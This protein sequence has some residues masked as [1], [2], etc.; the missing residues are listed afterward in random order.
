MRI[1]DPSFSILALAPFS[2]ALSLDEPPV[3]TVDLH[4][5]DDALAE[6][7]PTVDISMDATICP[8]PSLQVEI[9][10]MADFKPKNLVKNT[11]FLR[12]LH[13]ARESISGN[14]SPADLSVKYPRVAE[15]ITFPAPSSQE[16]KAKS[17]AI[18]D[19]LS[20]VD[21]GDEPSSGAA[22]SGDIPDQIDTLTAGILAT[23]LA[24]HDFRLMEQAWRGAQLVLRQAGSGTGTTVTMTLALLTQDAPSLVMD[25]LESDLADTPPDL[26]LLD[27]NLSHSPLDM[28][29]LHRVMG[30][31]ES[32]LAPALIP[33]GT[34]FFGI[35]DWSRFDTLGFIPGLLEGAEYGKW[36]TMAE[37]PGGGWLVP[38]VNGV[39]ARPAHRAEAGF[40]NRGFNETTPLFL[41]PAWGLAAL[42]TRSIAE[43]KRPTR[44]NDRATVT[45]DGMPMT[46][47]ASPTSTELSLDRERLKDF[48]QAGIT[49]LT[50]APGSDQVFVLAN[51]TLDS[52]PLAFRLFLSQLTGFLIG[53]ATHRSEEI[54][55]LEYD[56]PQAIS[57]FMQA[58]GLPAPDDLT[59]TTHEEQDGM[60]PLEISL[61]PPPEILPGG[62]RFTFG[63]GW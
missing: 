54:E 32:M 4:S 12:E 57:L 55:D 56:L 31:A 11:P 5:L 48:K 30:L 33:M 13:E 27:R 17:S 37:S 41:S 34:D 23:I 16:T 39:L 61:T 51:T 6:L 14:G 1:D 8:L 2:P 43:H 50:T 18:D 42:C 22:L 15:M 62:Q 24:D 7:A 53:L 3:F 21:T 19:I 26:I 59:V 46:E 10:R 47:G 36:K 20:M 25:M 49:P 44:F 45:L 58:M 29:I 35:P 63:F 9:K 40:A 60:T 52:G 38:C 28:D